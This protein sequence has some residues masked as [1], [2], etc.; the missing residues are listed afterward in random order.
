MTSTTQDKLRFP[1]AL[2]GIGVVLRAAY[3]EAVRSSAP[4]IELTLTVR[5]RATSRT[6][7]ETIKFHEAEEADLQAV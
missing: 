2:H 1:R 6:V 3:W 7:T 4:Q 5:V